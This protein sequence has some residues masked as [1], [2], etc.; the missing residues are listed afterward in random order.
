MNR[1]KKN[2]DNYFEKVKNQEVFFSEEDA[3][4]LIENHSQNFSKFKR[5]KNKGVKKMNIIGASVVGA[6][7]IGLLTFNGTTEKSDKQL[8]KDNTPVVENKITDNDTDHSN[9]PEPELQN[10]K[11]FAENDV[12]NIDDRVDKNDNAK[13]D[14]VNIIGNDIDVS[15]VNLIKLNKKEFEDIG[16]KILSDDAFE[17]VIPSE[18]ANIK[19]K[20]SLNEGIQFDEVY[21]NEFK[22]GITAP[23][24][25]TKESGQ[26]IFGR[27]E[28]EDNTLSMVYSRFFYD[29]TIPNNNQ[30]DLNVTQ[31]WKTNNGT[32]VYRLA[33]DTNK[34]HKKIHIVFDTA[35]TENN[36]RQITNNRIRVSSI[37][38]EEMKDSLLDP[39]NSDIL[40]SKVF[41]RIF[42]DSTL[43]NLSMND[44]GFDFDIDVTKE[45]PDK[46]INIDQYIDFDENIRV[47]KMLPLAYEVNGNIEYIFWFDP[48]KELIE[49]LPEE[50]Q[51]DLVN[52]FNLINKDDFCETIKAGEDTYFDILRSC[53]GS[54]KNLT[55]YPNPT[56]GALNIS[57]AIEEER[58]ISISLHDVSGE[59]IKEF[60][61]SNSEL[62]GNYEEL[63]DIS[64][65]P[66]GL[67]V[68]SVSNNKGEQVIQRVIKK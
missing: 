45:S 58:N 7:L 24:F 29:D 65:L 9:I 49:K 4:N 20:I 26:K 44:R 63:Y 2:I 47:N 50:Y 36:K 12:T 32:P 5:K 61:V 3:R 40:V 38:E 22:E 33:D 10:N 54:L 37:I 35:N 39:K 17:F 19:Y 21:D 34:V 15:K 59:K 31:T 60:K 27:F 30:I 66:A 1:N 13:S 41:E 18:L 62:K 43:K 53:D 14:E 23:T 55:V 28:S 68:V 8:V 57:Y 25:I 6:S 16:V 67:Y 48:T 46:I 64:E 42:A 56:A 51:D 11:L 52:Q